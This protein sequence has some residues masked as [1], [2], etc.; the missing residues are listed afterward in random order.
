MKEQEKSL[1][2]E[3]RFKETAAPSY[4]FGTMH[5][6]DF[7]AFTFIEQAYTKLVQCEAI[8]LEF[9]LEEAPI[10]LDISLL[11]LPKGQ[12]LEDLIP[13][14]KLKKMRDFL[15]KTTQIDLFQLRQYTPFFITNTITNQILANDMPLA[16]DQHL[17]QYAKK[18]GMSGFGLETYGEQLQ[19]LH[20]IPLEQQLKNMTDAIR[21][22]GNY[23]RSIR[24]MADLY[25]E[26]N[27]YKIY[28]A[29]KR[30]A[31]GARNLLLY[32]RN[33]VMASRMFELAENR[34]VFFAIGAGHLA[35]GKGVLR[36]LKHQGAS[37]KKVDID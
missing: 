31:S 4:L 18:H 17:W 32:K 3:I 26:G 20:S 25:K 10:G 28:K 30:S 9:N 23:R 35:G 14:R 7:R 16:L 24:K 12:N 2:W 29:A 15:I 36:L 22:I 34:P 5:V 21:H 33:K 19:I 13:P 1:L 37:I 11:H 6:R 27:I 8:A